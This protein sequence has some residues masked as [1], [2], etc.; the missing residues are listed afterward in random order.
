LSVGERVAEF[1]IHF[2]LDT[3][4][5]YERV[6]PHWGSI[7]SDPNVA[8]QAGFGNIFASA[9]M[10]IA[11]AAEHL[12]PGRFGES[13]SDGGAI[14]FTFLRP[15]VPGDRVLLTADVVAKLPRGDNTEVVLELKAT[16]ESGELVAVG[17]ARA[18]QQRS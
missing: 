11:F 16:L 8:A 17:S 10:L 1:P 12:L 3:I 15:L 13:W 14:A 4:L 2:D 6:H 7:H 9:T 5:A 18:A